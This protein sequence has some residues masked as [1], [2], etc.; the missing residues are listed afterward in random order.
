MIVVVLIIPQAAL[1]E[2]SDLENCRSACRNALNAADKAIKDLQ[3]DITLH[4]GTEKAQDDQI[5]ALSRSLNEKNQALDA[6]YRN[7]YTDV[8]IGIVLGGAVT[9]YL[10]R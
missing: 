9:L 2:S 8:L 10:T 7:P 4:V 6:W 1:C 3:D 5:A